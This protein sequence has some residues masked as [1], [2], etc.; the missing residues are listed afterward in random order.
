MNTAFLT[1]LFLTL[2]ISLILCS[3]TKT[4]QFKVNNNIIEIKSEP[5]FFNEVKNCIKSLNEGTF[6][7]YDYSEEDEI[8]QEEEDTIESTEDFDED[9]LLDGKIIENE[10][11]DTYSMEE[12]LE[13]LEEL[14]K[15]IQKFKEGEINE[16]QLRLTEIKIDRITQKYKNDLNNKIER[17]D[18]EQIDNQNYDDEE[19]IDEDNQNSMVKA[20]VTEKLE[21]TNDIDTNSFDE[22][23]KKTVMKLNL[24][25]LFTME[26]IVEVKSA[27]QL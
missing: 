24:M 2:N 19:Y 20:Y 27:A 18:L 15:E 11:T 1:F 10:T 5:D 4:S 17:T 6:I 9:E 26:A 25:K 7:H 23:L 13:E 16:E 14:Q 12:D 3:L 8:E 22:D 21:E